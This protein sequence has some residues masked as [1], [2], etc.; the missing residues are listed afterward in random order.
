MLDACTGYHWIFF[1]K[2]MQD[3]ADKLINWGKE[4]HNLTG[5]TIHEF[6]LDS[7]QEFLKINTWAIQQGIQIRNT[8]PDTPEPRGRI[9]RAGGVITTMARSAMIDANLPASL[10]PYAENWAVKVLN[11]L[12]ASANNN[13]D[14]P[15][16]R[17]SQ[18][19]QL[20]SDIHQPFVKHIRIFG[21][22]AWL[23]LKG[24]NAPK[25]GDKTAPRA[26]KGRYLGSC[27]R[28]GHVVYVWIPSKHQIA[29]ARDVTIIETTQQ[30]ED[31]VEEPE[32]IA[33]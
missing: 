29:T 1:A 6:L 20:H 19:L 31:E 14:S 11:L 28:K 23:L 12:P 24:H 16:L 27:S 32:Y 30:T 13:N 21:A 17:M 3:V 10:W 33:Q 8:S 5:L 22:T 7:G 2:S 9:E 15:H 25:K 18:L 4:I 26:I